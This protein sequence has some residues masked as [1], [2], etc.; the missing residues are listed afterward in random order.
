MKRK[1]IKNSVEYV[2]DIQQVLEDVCHNEAEK[3]YMNKDF[4]TTTVHDC[5]VAMKCIPCLQQYCQQHQN[6]IVINDQCKSAQLNETINKFIPKYCTNNDNELINLTIDYCDNVPDKKSSLG[7]YIAI[8]LVVL[9]LVVIVIVTGVIYIKLQTE[10]EEDEEKKKHKSQNKNNGDDDHRHHDDL[11]AS[12]AVS[13]NYI[14]NNNNAASSSANSSVPS[15]A[16]GISGVS[17][18]MS[19]T[20][21]VSGTS[22]ISGVSSNAASN[23]NVGNSNS[24]SSNANSSNASSNPSSVSDTKVQVSINPWGSSSVASSSKVP[25]KQKMIKELKNPNMKKK[26]DDN[27]RNKESKT[28]IA[29]PSV[30]TIRRAVL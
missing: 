8:G 20:S 2:D 28:I 26:N 30:S 22:G 16:P 5:C 24:I 17:G 4:N 25:I 7:L 18:T 13:S 14:N 21:G 15:G 23:S 12:V 1:I 19:S 11:P 9:L 10:S 3:L 29:K 6:S 27:N